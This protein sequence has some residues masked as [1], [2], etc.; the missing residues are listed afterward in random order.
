MMTLLLGRAGTGKT[1]ALL[2]RCAAGTIGRKSILIVPEQGSHETERALCAAGGPS[3]SMRAEVL[4]FTRLA[5]RV[6]A[7]CGGLAVPVLHEGGRLLLL[8]LAVEAVKT[9]LTV[10]RAA[11]SRPDFLPA[12]LQTIDE[13]K[14]CRLTPDRLLPAVEQAA[15]WGYDTAKLRDLALILEAYTAHCA[16]HAADPRDTMTRLAAA[17]E[18]NDRFARDIDFYIDDFRSFTA[19]EIRVLE[20][21]YR[22]SG[23]FTAAFCID[24]DDP[25]AEAFAEA[26]RT[27]DRFRR[28][29]DESG[30]TI[31]E[32][33]FTE[34]HRF[35]NPALRRVE[36][37]F[38]SGGAG[39]DVPVRPHDSVRLFSALTP[40]DEVEIVAAQIKDLCRVHGYRYREIAVGARNFDA[41]APLVRTVFEQCGIPAY[42]DGREE[43]SRHAAPTLLLA[44]A[45]A[46]ASFSP[47]AVLRL[48]KTGL[49]PLPL[50]DIDK[51]ENYALAW[52]LKP[53]HWNT[54][55]DWR[56][57]PRGF[58]S[59][60]TEYD[61]QA[62]AAINATRQAV[63]APLVQLRARVKANSTGRGI[64]RA[65]Y[66]FIEDIDLAGTL[67]RRAK[68]LAGRGDLLRAE[69]TGQLWDIIGS[70]LGQCAELLGERPID[71]PAYNE[72]LRRVLSCYSAGVIP[73]SLDHVQAGDIQR[74]RGGP[75]RAMFL[76]GA[77][78]GEL[79]APPPV[80]GI[81]DDAEREL[82]SDMGLDT[83]PTAEHRIEAEWGILYHALTRA[84]EHLT[85][86]W[87]ERAASGAEN[88]PSFAI[89]QLEKLLSLKPAARLLRP[90]VAAAPSTDSL[91]RG[92]LSPRHTAVLYG[93][94]ARM[95]VTRLEQH[96]LCAY[97]HFLKHGLQLRPRRLPGF[98]P[99]DAGIFLHRVL[100]LT[101]RDIMAGGGFKATRPE[102]AAAIAEAHA[103]AYALAVLDGFAGHPER[104]AQQF[105]RWTRTASG[106]AAELCL[107]LSRSDFV[108]YAFEWRLDQW[109][110]D[111]ATGL[112]IRLTGIADRI[113]TWAHDGSLYI[114]VADYKTG[115]APF[116]MGDFAHGLGLQLP[117][118]LSAA[119]REMQG[120]PTGFLTVP[121][122]ETTVAA[123]R[124]HSAADLT[125]LTGK[126]RQRSGLLLNDPAVLE[127]MERGEPKVYL[128]VG[129]TKS[130][131]LTAASS[132]ADA[133]QMAALGRFAERKAAEAASS[134]LRGELDCHPA[135]RG[136]KLVCGYCDYRAVCRYDET[137]GDTPRPIAGMGK[138]AF[139]EVV[140]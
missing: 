40:L 56:F 51:L 135:L 27:V 58:T 20:L 53:G 98:R 136:G 128:P 30:G 90:V 117:L 28:M 29:A 102:D 21:L 12:L 87:P 39:A 42:H 26:S 8:H 52:A 103:A 123:D 114:R 121:A 140:E 10:L 49:F 89:P 23:S 126:A 22:A 60:W 137:A 112:S 67:E 100:E 139:W 106:I 73:V 25:A 99:P 36:A 48:L 32:E 7:S 68:R 24:P 70:A 88:H 66:Q 82:L 44:A 6:F 50:E 86:S 104:L 19:Q 83:A 97:A 54:A 80:V 92:S 132:V 15:A 118:Y 59:E 55:A 138:Q 72:L 110:A 41:Y 108:P 94:P 11:A 43:V 105:T 130:G 79:P 34:R 3:A 62:L 16:Q 75:F 115:T 113:D 134:L 91:S 9:R 107:E 4:T 46:A 61:V 120:K 2:H 38:F 17:L 65:Y 96:A 116:R 13:C 78:E 76:L 18:N 109:I 101:A 119:V 1:T 69:V 95:S 77:I 111:P 93:V 71:L 57:H 37:G 47:D 133:C 31:R 122:R 14:A 127:A 81:L 129:Y 124:T 5:H 131:G 35:R 45:D 84:S 33:R 64:S 63:R 85:V 74:M 125:R